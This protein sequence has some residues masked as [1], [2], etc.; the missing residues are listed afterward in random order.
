M[1][2]TVTLEVLVG[3]LGNTATSTL[4]VC[5][6]TG[7]SCV[8][9]STCCDNPNQPWFKKK[10]TQPTSEDV[11]MHWC[12]SSSPAVEATATTRVELYIRVD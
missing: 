1:I 5:G 10:L 6:T 12:A 3:T 7:P 8:S 4:T 9:G 11:E 2:I